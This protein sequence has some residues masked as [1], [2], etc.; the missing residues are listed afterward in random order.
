[1]ITTVFIDIDNTLLDFDLSARQAMSAALKEYGVSYRDDMFP[2]FKKI[3]DDLWRRIE[4]GSLTKDGL[5][6]IRWLTVFAA[7]GIGGIDAE[8][9]EDKFHDLLAVSAAPVDGAVDLLE[10]LCK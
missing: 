1:M 8:E 2:T 3:N 7:L 6:K 5:R 9:F 10:Y 4:D